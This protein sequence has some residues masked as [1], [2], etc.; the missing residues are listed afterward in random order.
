MQTATLYTKM[1]KNL[2]QQLKLWIKKKNITQRSFVEEAL[3]NYVATLSK[4]EIESQYDTMANDNEYLEEMQL[5][6]KYLG[7][8]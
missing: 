7:N 2:Y 1:D 4:A 5:N 6:A 8:L 3:K